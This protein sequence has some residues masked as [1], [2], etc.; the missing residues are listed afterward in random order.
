MREENWNEAIIVAL[1]SNL[2]GEYGSSCAV[3][4]RALNEFSEVGLIVKAKS[5]VWRSNAWPDPSQ[6]SYFNAVARVETEMA[7]PRVL[8]ALHGLEARF[9]RSRSVANAARVLD[10]DLIAYGRMVSDNAELVLPHPRAAGRR[11]V[12]GPLAQVAPG[13]RHPAT[14]QTAQVLAAAAEVGRD[15]E[16]LTE[17][18]FGVAQTFAKPYVDRF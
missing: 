16:P 13:W 1:G 12:M 11:F 3:L 6:P 2:A 17:D 9:G 10:L 15:A 7:P 4:V 18:V 5:S 14:G 8:R